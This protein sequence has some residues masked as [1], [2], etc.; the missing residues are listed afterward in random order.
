MDNNENYMFKIGFKCQGYYIFL[1]M[2][3]CVVGVTRMG[4]CGCVLPKKVGQK[5]EK[6]KE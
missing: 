1:H 5:N 6:N 4:T 3:T 2:K